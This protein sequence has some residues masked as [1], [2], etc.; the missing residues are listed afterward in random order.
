M[1]LSLF[2][3]ETIKVLFNFGQNFHWPIKWKFCYVVK[4][5][6][7]LMKWQ[8]LVRSNKMS[9]YAMIYKKEL[10]Y[11]KEVIISIYNSV[12]KVG[13]LKKWDS[14]LLHLASLA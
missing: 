5:R 3:T 9:F 4:K 7:G 8:N 10:N 2:V 12:M 14:T 11:H 13:I 1:K 6:S